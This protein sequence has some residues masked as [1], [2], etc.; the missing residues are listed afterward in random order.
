MRVRR[1]FMVEPL[2]DA[3]APERCPPSDRDRSRGRKLRKE[4]RTP[5]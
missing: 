3:D 1:W 4:F 2:V 5:G